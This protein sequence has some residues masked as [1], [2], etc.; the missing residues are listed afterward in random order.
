MKTANRKGTRVQFWVNDNEY[1]ELFNLATADGCNMSELI[2]SLIYKQLQI[3]G[4]NDGADYIRKQIREE[5]RIQLKA[6]IE[7]LVK[8][9]IKIGM[10]EV[11]SFFYIKAVLKLSNPT[12]EEV[13]WDEAR[14]EAAAY[15]GMR[16]SRAAEEVYRDFT[17][18]Y[19]IDYD[20]LNY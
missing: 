1:E 3:N 16:N 5:I 8:V 10:I 4:A 2:R 7:R 14:K 20:D 13:L 18:N 15:L 11:S 9:I 12:L 19:S 6:Q 17:E